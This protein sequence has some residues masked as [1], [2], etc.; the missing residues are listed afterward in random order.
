MP[1]PELYRPAAASVRQQRDSKRTLLDGQAPG[2]RDW[3]ERSGCDDRDG[4][5][6]DEGL[7]RPHGMVEGGRRSLESG[8]FRAPEGAMVSSA[9]RLDGAAG[10]QAAN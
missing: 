5:V 4:L 10:C 1:V 2:K 6:Q 7:G 9:G 8:S 3:H